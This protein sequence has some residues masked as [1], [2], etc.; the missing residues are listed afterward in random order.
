[1]KKKVIAVVG[2][3]AVGKTK[4]SIAIAKQYNG[5]I[6]S[7]DSMQVYQGMDI[8]TAKITHEEM[9][10]V[11]HYLIDIKKPDESFSA[12]DFKHYVMEYIDHITSKNKIPIIVGGSGLYIQAALYNYNFPTHKKDD[13]IIQRIEKEVEMMG[14]EPAYQRLQQ[15][16]PQQASRI[17][18]NNHRRVIRALEIYESTGKTMTA[19]QKQQQTESPY[20]LKLIGLEMDRTMLYDRINQRVN[21]MIEKGLVEEVRSL[22]QAGYAQEQ[23]MRAIGYKEFIPYFEGESSLSETIETL[24]Q[25]SRRYAKRQYTWFRN[26]MNVDWYSIIPETINEKFRKI[27]YDLAGFLKDR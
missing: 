3:T 12:A 15:I 20:D 19:Y 10:G 5:E 9:Q 1:M 11:P 4:L 2:P 18:P 16:D 24:K 7:G 22:Y 14:I 23:A 25:N 26:K 6:I 8:G 13:R 21:E 27:L 17:H